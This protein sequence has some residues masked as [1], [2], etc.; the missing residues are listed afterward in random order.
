MG[1]SRRTVLL[2]DLRNLAD[3]SLIVGVQ[4]KITVGAGVSNGQTSGARDRVVHRDRDLVAF[5]T[6][7]NDGVLRFRLH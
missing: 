1:P 7:N 4:A 2:N 5:R 3:A 6:P